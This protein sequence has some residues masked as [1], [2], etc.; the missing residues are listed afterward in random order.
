V[1]THAAIIAIIAIVAP[2]AGAHQGRAYI[3]A[4]I[5]GHRRASS[6]RIRRSAPSAC[7]RRSTRPAHPRPQ[8]FQMRP[9]AHRD[10]HSNALRNQLGFLDQRQRRREVALRSL[11]VD[12]VST[13]QIAAHVGRRL[14]VVGRRFVIWRGHRAYSLLVVDCVFI[15]SLASIP[16]GGHG[17]RY[18]GKIHPNLMKS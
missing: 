15:V 11:S 5:A 16:E 17:R 8:I 7:E 10:R 1:D 3:A 6:R 14:S 12:L 4:I 18:E 13:D 2:N 9:V